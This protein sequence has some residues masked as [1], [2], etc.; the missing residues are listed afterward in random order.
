MSKA[1]LLM[2]LEALEARRKRESDDLA[3]VVHDL[4]LHQR[5][6]QAQNH[7]LL[8]MQQQLEQSRDRYA[9]LYEFSP[10]GYLGID[11]TGCV[12]VLN[13]TAAAILGAERTR[14]TGKPLAQ[15]IEESDRSRFHSHL[16]QCR[17]GAP[18]LKTGLRL[19]TAN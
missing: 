19:N 11:E 4:E 9:Q 15:Y 12:W 13:L 8:K 16:E 18:Q 1:E 6:L 10:V 14:L 17:S 7:D 5:Q 2:A 3:R